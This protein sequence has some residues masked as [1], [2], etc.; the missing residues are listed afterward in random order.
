MKIFMFI[1]WDAVFFLSS[2]VL[3][4]QKRAFFYL[5][6]TLLL[7]SAIPPNSTDY[8]IALCR[9]QSHIETNAVIVS[10]CNKN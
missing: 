1:F 8:H 10:S 4:I 9:A 5:H 3:P 2:A 7:L 6:S